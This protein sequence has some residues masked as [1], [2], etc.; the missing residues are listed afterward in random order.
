[1]AVDYTT[2]QLLQLGEIAPDFQQA[3]IDLASQRP[4]D[5][6]DGVDVKKAITQNPS[7]DVDQAS[8]FIKET[9]R[10]IPVRD[11]TEIP[12]RIYSPIDTTTKSPLV[13]NFHGGGFCFG[14]L[15][16]DAQFC[17][18]AASKYNAVVVDVDYRLAPANPFPVAVHDAYDAL[19]WVAANAASLNA[20]PELGF[21]ITGTSAG[22]NLTA[23]SVLR[24]RDEKLSPALT[25][26]LLLVPPTFS[27]ETV[28]ERFKSRWLSYE[29][30]KN[31]PVLN[32]ESID[33]IIGMY[34]PDH[35]S[36][37]YAPILHPNGFKG[38]PRTYIAVAG[39]DPLRDDGIIYEQVLR[40]EGVET[41]MVVYPGLCHAWW[42]VAPGLE[43]S[44][45]YHADNLEAVGW[46]LRR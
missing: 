12:I 18:D 13:I 7:K 2:E 17:R 9:D 22:A 33:K 35:S 44:L 27:P 36:P 30:N 10:K 3:L 6:E 16:S 37:D 46:L 40:E 26:Q 15:S 25:G 38:L 24:A 21:L 41:K 8:D 11:G 39:A 34:N 1:M 23:A 45:K 28:P 4:S 19:K 14:D 20:N 29:Q 5:S 32:R 42:A 43:A 31:A